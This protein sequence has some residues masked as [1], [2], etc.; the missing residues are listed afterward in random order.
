MADGLPGL[1]A[2][3]FLT[4]NQPAAGLPGLPAPG[5][6][7][8]NNQPDHELSTQEKLAGLTGALGGGQTENW[9]DEIAAGLRSGASSL[10]QDV[11][12]SPNY[13]S[14]ENELAAIRGGQKQFDTAYPIESQSLH[15]I[16]ATALN[17]ANA[18]FGIGSDLGA[19][20]N[21]AKNA[22][23]GS[24]LAGTSAA[25][26]AET[27]KL[28]AAEDA[29]PV[30]ALFGGGLSALGEGLSGLGGTAEDASLALDRKSIGARAADY[31]KTLNPVQRIDT[32]DGAESLTKT[33]LDDLL[34]NDKLGSTRDPAKLLKVVSA[35][36]KDLGQQVNDAITPVDAARVQDI[37]PN[38][39]NTLSYLQSSKMPANEIDTYL[40]KL[41]D[42]DQAIKQE[43]DG[44]L[45]YLQG[46]KQSLTNKWDPANKVGNNFW[47]SVYA[48]M[49]QTIENHVPEVKAINKETQK[50]ILASPII[51]RA[52][53]IAENA[54]PVTGL[55]QMH[56]TSGGAGVP[57]MA[58][59]VSGHP[60]IGATAALGEWLART[61]Q[62][63][64]QLS[65]LTGLGS[66][67]LSG[68][69]SVTSA[70]APTIGSAI[71]GQKG[72]NMDHSAAY[73][74]AFT[75]PAIVAP[76]QSNSSDYSPIVEKL[77]P[78]ISAVESSGNPGAVGRLLPDGQ[79]AQGEFQFLPST[80]KMVNAEHGTS[81]DP[82]TKEGG[83]GL[84]KLYM[85]DLLQQTHGNVKLALAKYNGAKTP[86]KAQDY[87]DAV[88]SKLKS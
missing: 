76:A 63:L 53:G 85:G 71:L 22:G 41:S 66:D 9:I 3:G 28:Q 15:A 35:K 11:G 59:I 70:A 50:Y 29:A 46:Q 18:L 47:R 61:P 10:R 13:G 27:N 72:D 16:G 45:A 56:R 23:I 79:R 67:V 60:L 5:F 62:G 36:M 83:E 86:S 39:N 24:I 31:S 88:F 69:G 57:L 81:F 55:L 33:A 6:L 38:W 77:K 82:K 14:Y 49:Q 58:G 54:D 80:A 17:P 40:G 64:A 26:N 43:G 68:L 42:Y 78:A 34:S 12:L 4:A 74:P 20:G 1:P 37:T 84:F 2:P 7:S 44:S 73:R 48:D 65:N 19:A 75:P 8:N 32:P 51:Q 87:I 21:I 52:A 30:G 25:G